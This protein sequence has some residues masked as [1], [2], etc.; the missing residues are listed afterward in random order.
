MC[1]C[2]LGEGWGGVGFCGGFWLVG[3]F[4]LFFFG[5]GGG[6]GGFFCLFLFVCLFVVV[7]LLLFIQLLKYVQVI[8]ND[9]FLYLCL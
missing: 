9:S 7:F 1:V 2:V 6:V 8:S 3:L 4:V 5:G